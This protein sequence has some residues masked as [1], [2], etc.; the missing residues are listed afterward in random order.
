MGDSLR[1]VEAN[2]Y[3]YIAMIASKKI[4]QM[5]LLFMH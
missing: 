1:E 4:C 5:D 2:A 3:Y